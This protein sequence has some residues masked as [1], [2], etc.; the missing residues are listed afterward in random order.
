ME[1][2][3]SFSYGYKSN[4]ANQSRLQTPAGTN[5][6]KT[7]PA[8]Q[9]S[10]N[11]ELKPGQIIKGEVVDLRYQEVKIRLEP[12]HQVITARLSGDVSL[13]IGQEAQFQVTADNTERITLKY[14][15]EDSKPY[16][17][18][19]IKK[20]LEASGL[21]QSDRNKALVL[22]LLNNKMPIDK[23]TLMLLAKASVTNREASPQTLVLLYKNHIPL[24]QANIRQFAVYQE[25]NHQLLKD[26]QQLS[27][28]I[29][30]L[31]KE[32][33]GPTDGQPAAGSSSNSQA[34]TSSAS[35]AEP[36]ELPVTG[37]EATA[38][39]MTSAGINSV[40][41]G[42]CV[43]AKDAVISEISGAERDTVATG[44]SGTGKDTAAAEPIG[45]GMNIAAEGLSGIGK[46][47]AMGV[48]TEAGKNSDMEELT[49][50]KKDAA[51]TSN[52]TAD[53]LRLLSDAA[54]GHPELM[55]R[56]SYQELPIGKLL[57]SD[58]LEQL[59]RL[60]EQNLRDNSQLPA[61][62]QA[63]QLTELR[64]GTTL[65]TDVIKQV[66]QFFGKELIDQLF[67][68][69]AAG[70]SMDSPEFRTILEEVFRQKWT[71]TPEKLAK[72]SPL[73]DLYRDLQE[74]LKKINDIIS[75]NKDSAEGTRLQP[76][77]RN[78]Q[79]NLQFMK[80]LNDLFTYV[81]LPIQFKHQDVHGDLYVFNRKNAFQGK[82][83]HMSVLLH[84]D[85]SALGAL[86][87]HL[88]ME[89]NKLQATFYIDDPVS[90]RIIS[91]HLPELSHALSD[92]GYYL[93]A[94]VEQPEQ[95]PDFIKDILE[96]EQSDSSALRYSFD[97]RA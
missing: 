75:L 19:T 59:Y 40:K 21:P 78:L 33:E 38:D 45:T 27:K 85:M 54:S 79:D 51:L 80:E 82:K 35:A 12:E 74:D 72:K 61:E 55:D 13:S 24:T 71:I 73:E 97:I 60:M 39:G 86:N 29:F 31:L 9:E 93:Q 94:R 26:I 66:N 6:T 22:E 69:A 2:F 48:M 77:V 83:D 37:K 91:E 47:T 89:L 44:L 23:Q 96:Q 15:P 42:L 68:E 62:Q 7:A 64:N 53:I 95:K 3:Q 11:V 87:V 92:K 81:Q 28:N 70:Q 16:L 1:I 43:G 25:G 84:L 34:S 49:G 63:E 4:K 36:A 8:E 20:A 88:N 14:L 17:D 32:V 46:D 58:G 57:D 30:K 67:S 76:P 18:Q 52:G 56:Q 41:E 50:A 65:F 90:G 10:K 5:P